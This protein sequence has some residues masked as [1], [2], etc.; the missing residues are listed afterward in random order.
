MSAGLI[1]FAI[2]RILR[3]VKDLARGAERIAGGDF[4]YTIN[5]TTG[6]EIQ[7]L[8]QQFNLMA[9]ALKESYMV[10]E[11]RSRPVKWCKSASSC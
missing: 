1:F 7:E 2:G 11:Q 6:D 8:S 4:D 3:P 5:A 10:L 9:G